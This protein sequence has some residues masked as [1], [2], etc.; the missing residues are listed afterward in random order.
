MRSFALASL[1]VAVQACLLGCRTIDRSEFFPP[2][3]SITDLPR[4]RLTLDPELT[5]ESA[6]K[7]RRGRVVGPIDSIE[8]ENRVHSEA[9]ELLEVHL[10]EVFSGIQSD[11]EV[12]VR[13]RVDRR[14]P[15]GWGLSRA[16]SGLTLTTINLLGVPF[17]RHTMD[18]E[19]LLVVGRQEHPRFRATGTGSAYATYWY[20]YSDDDAE[21]VSALRAAQEALR[22][23]D[24]TLQ[25][26]SQD[27]RQRLGHSGQGQEGE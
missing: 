2:T 5:N 12:A 23:L 15:L 7:T 8:R 16:L 10:S 26:N 18:I 13:Y 4:A 6:R 21:R 1:I 22:R 25:A 3:P 19:I 11:E 27:L 9:D 20:G 24:I 14:L 17:Y